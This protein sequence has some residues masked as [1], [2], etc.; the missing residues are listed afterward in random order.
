MQN[1][2]Y[3]GDNLEILPL[4]E[5]ESVDLCYID[6]PFN[7]KR[8]YNQIYN[9]IGVKDKAQAQAF[10]DT[11]EWDDEAQ[12][13]FARFNL[14]LEKGDKTIP[15][16]TK[17]LILALHKVL[18]ESGMFAYLV[19]MAQRILGIYRILKPTGSFYLHCD[20][21]ASHYLKL[22]LDSIFCRNGGDFQNE[23][24][25]KRYAV[26][27]LANKKFDAIND[28]IF[29]YTKS[30]NYTFNRPYEILTNAEI[31]KKFPYIET[32]TGRRFQTVALEQASNKNS[33]G[34]IRIVQGKNLTTELGWRWTQKEFDFRIAKN[35]HIIYWT[36]NGRP[37]Y[38][39]YADEYLGK[40][41]GSNWGDIS[42]LSSNDAER[43]GYPTQKPEKLLERIIL[44]SSKEKDVILDA[45]CGCGTTVAVAQRLK[46][47]WIGIDITY[48]SISLI[49][50]RLTDSY[51]KSILNKTEIFGIPKDVAAARDLAL[52]SK[53]RKEFE[54][55]AIITYSDN[56]AI[57][58][59]K[60]GADKGID[61][62]MYFTTS[63]SPLEHGTI[64]FSVKS[65]AVG[66]AQVRDFLHVIEREN[67]AGGVFLTLEEPTKPM[68]QEAKKAGKFI[69]PLTDTSFD[70]LQIVTIK[71]MIEGARANFPHARAVLNDAKRVKIDNDNFIF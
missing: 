2:L 26:H 34:E 30:K 59:E 22:L 18:G 37:R 67:A 33:R 12:K 42:Y 43:L 46:R 52:K 14:D 7:S 39:I 70:K 49:I 50:K 40:P 19:S 62:I 28:S 60:K 4:L 38:K 53:T 55:W 17:I 13:G 41:I 71:E 54:I 65:G 61:G 10:T 11:W 66:V 25:W 9:N 31:D 23:I 35:P 5:K 1:Q 63:V 36:S 44:A 68:L 6:P 27:S 3:Y 15:E 47:K 16:K 57:P 51:G 32:E 56:L 24:V 8:N 64:L 21:T 69:N 58:N 29:F 45:Y 48:N 20:P